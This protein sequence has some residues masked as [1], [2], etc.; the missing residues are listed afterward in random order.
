MTTTVVLFEHAP[1]VHTCVVPNLYT[2]NKR[3]SPAILCDFPD[4][5]DVAQVGKKGQEFVTHHRGGII[6]FT[7]NEKTVTKHAQET[8]VCTMRPDWYCTLTAG[9]V[10]LQEL[11]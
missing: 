2:R 1:S 8:P 4:W 5:E 10:R 11:K 7:L 3:N 9:S 6:W